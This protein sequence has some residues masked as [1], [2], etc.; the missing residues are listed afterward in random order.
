MIDKWIEK[1]VKFPKTH[2]PQK[3]L[4]SVFDEQKDKIKWKALPIEYCMILDSRSRDRANPVIEHYQLSRLYKSPLKQRYGY[5]M[6]QSFDEIQG[7][8]KGK[9]ICLIGNADSVLKEKR[10]LDKFDI[11]CRMNRGYPAG[12]EAFIGNRTDILFLS[13]FM[14]NIRIQGSYKPKHVVWMTICH[15]LA[16]PWVMRNAI[17]NPR[18]DWEELYKE[19]HINPTTGMM[20][21]KFILK[22]IK[23]KSLNIYGFDFFATKT[24]YN[25][26]ID[27]GQKHS[28]KKEKVI[29]MNMIRDRMNVRFT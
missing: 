9:R 28:G 18:E 26:R 19:L 2:M 17:Q 7:L 11:L 3:N 15:R 5:N 23:F 24:W 13:T 6:K 10:D 8:C 4:R 21:L 1:D 16:S 25:T 12:K 29:F 22:H 20:A 14:E 27:S